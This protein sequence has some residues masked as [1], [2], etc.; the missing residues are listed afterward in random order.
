MV[1]IDRHGLGGFVDHQSMPGLRRDSF[2]ALKRHIAFDIG[3]VLMPPRAH[4]GKIAEKA[5]HLKPGGL[6]V[7]RAQNEGG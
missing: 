7:H 3:A 2:E 6:P 5:Q 4:A 1:F